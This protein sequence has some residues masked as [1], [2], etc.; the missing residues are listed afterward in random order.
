MWGREVRSTEGLGAAAW[1]MHRLHYISSAV[2]L[3]TKNLNPVGAQRPGD[4]DREMR[5]PVHLIP[6]GV[7]E[8][9]P[10]DCVSSA[11]R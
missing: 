8:P 10:A 11:A 6:L 1:L 7:R 3:T 2:Y 5:T 4:H 9:S